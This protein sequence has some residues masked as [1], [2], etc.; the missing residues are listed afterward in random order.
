[1]ATAPTIDHRSET[2]EVL[3]TEPPKAAHIVRD[4][5][6][7]GNAQAIVLEARITGTPVEALCGERF[8][9]QRDPR[10]LPLCGVCKEI[11]DMMRMANPN[12]RDS[13]SD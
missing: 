5:E 8:V 12:L 4:P 1:M 13:P 9:P 3:E 11:Y 6:N 7:K 2:D 10:K